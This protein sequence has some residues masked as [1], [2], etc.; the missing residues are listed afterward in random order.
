MVGISFVVLSQEPAEV[1]AQGAGVPSL[2]HVVLPPVS[3]VDVEVDEAAVGIDVT[4]VQH[5]V[6]GEAVRHV[7]PALVHVV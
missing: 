3:S 4:H 5:G 7:E 1:L 6:V 2:A